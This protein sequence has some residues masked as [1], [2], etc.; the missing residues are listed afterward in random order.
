MDGQC[1]KCNQLELQAVI[2]HTHSHT[3][4]P[5]QIAM[6]FP[7]QTHARAFDTLFISCASDPKNARATHIYDGYVRAH[8]CAETPASNGRTRP[9]HTRGVHR[10]RILPA[11]VAH[12]ALQ[13]TG[14]INTSW[15]RA[16]GAHTFRSPITHTHTVE[17]AAA[18]AAAISVHRA[19]KSPAGQLL[20]HMIFERLLSVLRVYM[21]CNT[22]THSGLTPVYQI[23]VFVFISIKYHNFWISWV[24]W[25]YYDGLKQ[26]ASQL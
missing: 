25:L 10:G 15:L 7:P 14:Q 24:C 3:L 12:S 5:P 20:L 11:S 17:A 21:D 9:S 13:A 18:A 19:L 23:F 4:T 2:I 26:N 16:L 22:E 8:L 1:A 6:Q